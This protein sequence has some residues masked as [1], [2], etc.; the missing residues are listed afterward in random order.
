MIGSSGCAGGSSRFESA[1]RHP[2]VL[3]RFCL[4]RRTLSSAR[5]PRHLR[6]S[7]GISARLAARRC[8]RGQRETPVFA[9]LLARLRM[10]GHFGRPA[11]ENRGVPGSNPGLAIASASRRFV[12][13]L[14]RTMNE[15]PAPARHPDAG[16]SA[17]V[18]AD[19]AV[20]S[21]R[22]M[23][24][25]GV[26]ITAY[27]DGPYL[28]RGPFRMLDQEGRE[29]AMQRPTIALCR[30]GKSQLRPLCDGTHRAIG[31]RAMSGAEHPAR[32]EPEPEQSHTSPNGNLAARGQLR[33]LRRG[34][35]EPPSPGDDQA[36]LLEAVREA[37]RCLVQ[38]L[39]TASSAGDYAAMSLAEPLLTAAR[40]ILEWGG[41]DSE[42]LLLPSQP[43]GRGPGGAG[44]SRSQ[45]LVARALACARRL[46]ANEDRRFHQVRSLLADA[47]KALAS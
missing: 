35:S 28:V 19:V 3:A 40:R 39:S 13:V 42:Q 16:G 6:V 31:F 9:G 33:P 29:I 38:A 24:E 12:T 4:G 5:T 30:C 1:S 47:A 11:A 10:A 46:E 41:A 14:P 8:R 17:L 18:Y 32:P 15:A 7:A 34:S 22:S 27:Q 26:T 44:R 25:G 2:S 36:A 21:R 45:E 23:S 20:G 43:N 37:E